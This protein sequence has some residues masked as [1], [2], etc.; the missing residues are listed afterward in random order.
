MGVCPRSLLLVLLVILY[1][2]SCAVGLL[3]DIQYRWS[4]SLFSTS[5]LNLACDNAYDTPAPHLREPSS[6]S[7]AP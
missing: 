3:R 7:P 1:L 4:L 6:S 2:Q 5:M